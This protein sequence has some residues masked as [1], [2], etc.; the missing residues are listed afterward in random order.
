MSGGYDREPRPT[1]DPRSGARDPV[2][3]ATAD[4]GRDTVTPEAGR[5]GPPPSPPRGTPGAPGA[6][7]STVTLLARLRGL[8]TSRP[9]ATAAW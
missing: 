2:A 7:H 9:S 5:D 1:P 8:S 3:P 4:S 6:S